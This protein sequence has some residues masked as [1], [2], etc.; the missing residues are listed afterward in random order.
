M[1][2][3]RFIDIDNIESIS[4]TINHD[5]QYKIFR[6]IE[7]QV[8]RIVEDHGEPKFC[9]LNKTAYQQYYVWC[10]EHHAM[11]TDEIM[12]IPIVLDWTSAD[13]V[14]VKMSAFDEWRH[15]DRLDIEGKW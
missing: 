8:R 12:G 14:K 11:A 6:E 13:L 2:F 4:I 5:F 1:N 7:T 10:I 9:I 15:L 3:D